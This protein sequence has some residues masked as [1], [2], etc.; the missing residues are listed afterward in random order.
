M[1]IGCVKTG[2][3]L[4]EFQEGVIFLRRFF[5]LDIK[6]KNRFLLESGNWDPVVEFVAV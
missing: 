2:R 3:P 5:D 4:L 6:T 1:R